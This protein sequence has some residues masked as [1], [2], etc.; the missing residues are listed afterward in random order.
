MKITDKIWG[1]SQ[2]SASRQMNSRGRAKGQGISSSFFFGL[3]LFTGVPRRLCCRLFGNSGACSAC[4]QSI[5]ASELVMRAQGNVYHLKVAF[6]PPVFLEEFYLSYS[7]T[8]H[9]S[10]VWTQ[11]PQALDTEGIY[12][13]CS[14]AVISTYSLLPRTPHA[15][16][17]RTPQKHTRTGFSPPVAW[18]ICCVQAYC[19]PESHRRKKHTKA[20]VALYLMDTCLGTVYKLVTKKD[21]ICTCFQWVCFS[22][23]V[24][25]ML[26]LPESP[27]PRR[28]VSLH[29]WQFILWTR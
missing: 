19:F 29:Q 14:L 4:G 17:T 9:F 15:P 3:G 28:S 11:F 24:F 12:W 6:A 20:W 7:E 16:Y 5:P 25:Y 22:L 18:C 1:L 21:L 10:L 26:Y 8:K 2:N 27:G 23:S 13:S